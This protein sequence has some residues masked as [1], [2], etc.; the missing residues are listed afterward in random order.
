MTADSN[1]GRVPDEF[2]HHLSGLVD[3]EGHF[4]IA[5][6]V[7]AR[8]G[9]V[10]YGCAFKMN[11]R[12]DDHAVLEMIH[13]RTGLGVLYMSVKKNDRKHVRDAKPM[14]MWC[15]QTKAEC[16]ELVEVFERF[17]LWTKKARDF[18]IWAKAVRYLNAGRPEGWE[19]L[20]RWFE[21]IRA[22]RRYE[23]PL[24]VEESFELDSLTLFD[25]VDE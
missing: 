23:A 20:A 6:Q 4:A 11:L 16:L 18:H 13:E 12:D 21:E 19:P 3:G 22:V 15:V 14:T 1:G 8:T 10:A 7:K 9:S 25:E 17:P 2:W 24:S 5:K